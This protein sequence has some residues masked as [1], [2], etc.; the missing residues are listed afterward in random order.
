M[1]LHG[2]LWSYYIGLTRRSGSVSICNLQ[3]HIFRPDS[4]ALRFRAIIFFCTRELDVM[5]CKV[6]EMKGKKA[7]LFPLLCTWCSMYRLLSHLL[8]YIWDLNY[9]LHSL[10]DTLHHWSLIKDGRGELIWHQNL[11]LFQIPLNLKGHHPGLQYQLKNQV[12][13]NYLKRERYVQ[14]LHQNLVLFFANHE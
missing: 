14:M 13:V 10:V 8:P 4:R 6:L 2:V 3:V 5:A 9:A 11:S 12:L 7:S 1:G